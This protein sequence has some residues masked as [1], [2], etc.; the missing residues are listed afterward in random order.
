MTGSALPFELCFVALFTLVEAFL[1]L[2]V[3]GPNPPDGPALCLRGRLPGPFG[4]W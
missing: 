1:L 4:A 3:E 2:L